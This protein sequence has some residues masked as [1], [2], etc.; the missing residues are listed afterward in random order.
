MCFCKNGDKGRD[1]KDNTVV[2]IKGHG[3]HS[4]ASA[5]G[6]KIETK[7]YDTFSVTIE[8]TTPCVEIYV[9]K[10]I[11]KSKKALHQLDTDLESD[12][13]MEFDDVVDAFKAAI[14]EKVDVISISLGFGIP[15]V[16]SP[17][18]LDAIA[19]GSFLA[20]EANILTIAACGNK[21]PRNGTVRNTAPWIL[22]VGATDSEKKFM[23]TVVIDEKEFEVL[24]S[25][26][27]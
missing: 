23:T 4:A 2:D 21:G 27:A 13:G 16:T 25:L 11:W 7:L 12:F 10:V 9:Y 15:E 22:T 24:V 6:R 14:E 1:S 20:M 26:L 5:A 17:Y 3:T 8:G 19:V 18:H